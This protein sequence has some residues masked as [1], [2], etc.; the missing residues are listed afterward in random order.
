MGIL[1]LFCRRIKLKANGRRLSK[2]NEI[3]QSHGSQQS[4]RSLPPTA[5]EPI[6]SIPRNCIVGA[7]V[8]HEFSDK[9]LVLEIQQKSGTVWYAQASTMEE[10]IDW[11]RVLSPIPQI[12]NPDM[13][14][15]AP[16]VD[17]RQDVQTIHSQNNAPLLYPDISNNMPSGNIPGP[18]PPYSEIVNRSGR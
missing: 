3:M 9:P 14:P 18:P 4:R 11:I 17:T 16:L 1:S 13:Y 5:P 15:T 12:L 8:S 7:K 6:D 2:L 10:L